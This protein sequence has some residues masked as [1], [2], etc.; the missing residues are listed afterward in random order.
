MST[1][2]LGVLPIK[3]RLLPNSQI[4]NLTSNVTVFEDWAFKEA[5]KVK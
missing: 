2:Y 5:I 1:F 3:L 4:E